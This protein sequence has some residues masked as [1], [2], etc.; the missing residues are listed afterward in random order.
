MSID[1]HDL[2]GLARELC[3]GSTEAHWRSAVSRAYYG[4]YHACDQWHGR[5]PAPGSDIGPKGGVHQTL[6]NRLRNPA[7]EVKGAERALSKT[8]ATVLEVLRVQ[9]NCADYDLSEHVDATAARNARAKAEE[10][11]GKL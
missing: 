5:L 10:I 2:L 7:P 1:H 4:A 6:I 11:L 3:D 9:R 8:L